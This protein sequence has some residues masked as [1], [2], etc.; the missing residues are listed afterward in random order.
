M[1]DVLFICTGNIYRS[2]IAEFLFKKMF[3]GLKA[4]SAGFSAMDAGKTLRVTFHD[5]GLED[6][7]DELERMGVHISGNRCKLVNKEDMATSRLILVM[8][9]KHKQRL[10]TLFPEFGD[11]VFLLREFAKLGNV[12]IQDIEAGQP[13]RITYG[14]IK[15]ALEKIR[16]EN[17]LKS[18]S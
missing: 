3:P 8:E 4:T 6:V 16:D 2:Q 14:Q 10:A 7:L 13:V 11:K 5:N 1:Y 9:L 15:E 18:L 17:L 12:E